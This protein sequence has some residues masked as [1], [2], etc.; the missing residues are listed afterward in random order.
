[1]SS[2]SLENGIYSRGG[3]IGGIQKLTFSFTNTTGREER[4]WR[5][6]S[7][8]Y[9]CVTSTVYEVIVPSNLPAD[10]PALPGE[11]REPGEEPCMQVL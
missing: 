3:Q 7:T 2:C 10:P 1:M 4:A 8:Q 9:K 11:K 5:K 6:P